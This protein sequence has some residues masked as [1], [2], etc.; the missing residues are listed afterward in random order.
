[1][2]EHQVMSWLPKHHSHKRDF[3]SHPNAWLQRRGAN[4]RK[5]RRRKY[6]KMLSPRPLQAIVCVA[7]AAPS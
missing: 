4:S 2:A 1:M 7:H 3:V 6:F 5:L